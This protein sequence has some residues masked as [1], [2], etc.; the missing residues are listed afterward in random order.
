ML[1]RVAFV[2]VLAFAAA[3]FG[4]SSN[5][6]GDDDDGSDGNRNGKGNG[7]EVEL[8]VDDNHGM[9]GDG[10]LVEVTD[11][12]VDAM[13]SAGCAGNSFEPETIPGVPNVSVLCFPK[14]CNCTE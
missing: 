13:F 10:G 12:E 4:C 1:A 9:S 14:T 6:D 2:G 3:G 11:D 5:K 7:P 8:E